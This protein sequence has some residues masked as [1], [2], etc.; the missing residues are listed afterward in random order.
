MILQMPPSNTGCRLL[1]VNGDEPLEL[2][3][4]GGSTFWAHL[5][6]PVMRVMH[7]ATLNFQSSPKVVDRDYLLVDMIYLC[8]ASVVLVVSIFA[9]RALCIGIQMAS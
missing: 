7:T 2:V 3:S 9:A 1:L 8:P 5:H 4:C 6:A